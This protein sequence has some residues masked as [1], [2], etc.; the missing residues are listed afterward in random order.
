MHQKL[1]KI[2]VQK[3]VFIVLW[4]NGLFIIQIFKVKE[5]QLKILKLALGSK[6]VE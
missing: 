2:L 3:A 6:I 1:S 5:I 4:I